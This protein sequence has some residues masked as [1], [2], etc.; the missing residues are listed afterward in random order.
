MPTTKRKKKA[1]KNVAAGATVRKLDP[2][3]AGLDRTFLDVM[4]TFSKGE[5]AVMVWTLAI[6]SPYFS[7]AEAIGS[8]LDVAATALGHAQIT[9]MKPWTRGVL[10]KARD[11]SRD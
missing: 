7:E 11:R 4:G 5:L 10:A 1:P 3:A 2:A 9:A 8:P 6:V